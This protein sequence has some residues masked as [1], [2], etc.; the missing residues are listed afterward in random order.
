MGLA[1]PK[2]LEDLA[3]GLI[4]RR[5]I[6]RDLS[7]PD[8]PC[9]SPSREPRRSFFIPLLTRIIHEARP[10]SPQDAPC[11]VATPDSILNGVH[12]PASGRIGRGALPDAPWHDSD[13]TF[14]NNPG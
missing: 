8:H 9:L 4:P 11:C 1:P 7:L 10:E 3:R 14:M 5:P 13:S 6:S 12:D 2:H